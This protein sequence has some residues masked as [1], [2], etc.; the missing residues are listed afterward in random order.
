MTDTSLSKV[1]KLDKY[2]GDMLNPHHREKFVENLKMVEDIIDDNN[3]ERTSEDFTG[4]KRFFF[5]SLEAL[6]IN[7]D[8]Y[9]GS[10]SQRKAKR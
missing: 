1:L 4:F 3:L 5:G 6:D 8:D 7:V 9:I 2:G 10:L